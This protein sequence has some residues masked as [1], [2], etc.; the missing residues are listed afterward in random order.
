MNMQE[1]TL[2]KISYSRKEDCRIMDSVLRK[3]FKD[4]KVLNLVSPNL[5]YPFNFKDWVSKNYSKRQL[6]SISIVI[7]KKRWIVGH[8]SFRVKK[9]EAHIFHLVIDKHYRRLGL[10][11]MLI[12]EVEKHCLKLQKIITLK[13]L[14][15]N[16]EAIN[17]YKN[18]GYTVIC[19][20]NLRSVKMQK[21]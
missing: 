17:L 3:W 5:K 1:Y 7:L 10:A 16:Q 18:L 8:I 2:E 6:Q 20:E 9:N 4:P 13:I 21:F 12:A 15:K 19:G 14:Q 11:K